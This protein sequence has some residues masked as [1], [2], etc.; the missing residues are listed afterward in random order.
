[1]AYLLAM[2]KLTKDIYFC[3]YDMETH[4]EQE[5]KKLEIKIMNMFALVERALDRSVQ[6]LISRDDDL[7]QQVIE[8]DEGINSL[9]LEVEE[10]CLNI[11]ALWQPVARDLRLVTGC[12]KISTE[13]ERL[14]DQATN[15]S[16]RA[17]ILN[18]KPRVTFMNTI[19]EMAD[20]VLSMY[21]QSIN[22]YS[23]L[24]CDLARKICLKDSEADDFNI[25]I[26]KKLIDY[27]ST[28][29]IIVERAVHSIIVSNSLERVGDL[30][31]NI[32]EHIFFIARGINIRHSQKLDDYYGF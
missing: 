23:N 14:G 5:L 25:K 10:I 21:K 27:M 26:I 1:V 24:D 11:L 2:S 6:A 8:E 18:K 31:T 12:S 4:L 16:E 15:I 30:A 29:S 7:A 13:L 20:L 3:E 19:K 17:I 9:E 32:C 28:E 22:S